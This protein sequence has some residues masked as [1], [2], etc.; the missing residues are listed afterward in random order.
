MK[1]TDIFFIEAIMLILVY[2]VTACKERKY[3][4]FKWTGDE[5][6]GAGIGFILS[7]ALFLLYLITK[8]R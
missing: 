2:T 5:I 7:N 1:T 8:T 3:N 4:I 6:D